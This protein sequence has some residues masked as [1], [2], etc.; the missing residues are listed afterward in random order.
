MADLSLLEIHPEVAAALR[1]NRPVVALESALI[2]HGLPQPD[3]LGTAR[4]A[5][6][7][8]R[9]SG[10]TP[11]TIAVRSGRPTVG[12]TD[13]QIEELAYCR[14]AFKASRR[15]L[16][17]AVARQ[18]IAGTTVS[19][20]MLLAHLAG[21]RFLATGGIGGAHPGC[22]TSGDISADLMELARTPVAV[23]CAGAKSILDIPRTLE[24]LET[25]G[26]PIIGYR[27]HEFP[28]FF[29][30]T[31]GEPVSE[32]V[33]NPGQFA[34]LARAHWQLGGAGLV[35]AQ[36]VN[37]DVA[38]P[39]EEFQHGL[40]EAERQAR[41]AAVR[42]PQTTPFLLNRLAHITEG[43]TLRANQALVVANAR[44]AAQVAREFAECS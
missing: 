2:T 31:S 17:A 6:A 34:V 4:A 10:A 26:V 19:S 21:I 27:T 37:A 40:R 25:E 41:A 29:V 15:D 22:E 43:K 32:R 35:L 36:P 5:A 30:Q 23:I 44:L 24:I 1:E 14:D 20:T 3:N 33:E 12:L 16:A 39:P 7:A 8:V 42:G 9:E 38:L 11:A 28:A 13:E 18:R